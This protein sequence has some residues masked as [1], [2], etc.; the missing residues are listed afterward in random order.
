MASDYEDV[1]I[2]NGHKLVKIRISESEERD[3]Q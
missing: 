1:Y 2:F 3:Y